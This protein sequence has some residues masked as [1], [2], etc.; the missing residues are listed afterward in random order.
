MTLASSG[1]ISFNDIISELCNFQSSRTSLNDTEVR[2]L[3]GVPSG[4]IN[5][6][7]FYGK[8]YD[9]NFF[10]SQTEFT[11]N[12]AGGID[13]KVSNSNHIYVAYSRGNNTMNKKL[14][15]AKLG[16]SS[17]LVPKWER[18]YGG[19]NSDFVPHSMKIDSSE[20][21]YFG[22]WTREYSDGKY[23]STIVKFDSSG[24]FLWDKRCSLSM[25]YD[26]ISSGYQACNG[27]MLDESGNVYLGSAYRTSFSN[28]VFPSSGGTVVTK[29]DSDG[30]IIWNKGYGFGSSRIL[31]SIKLTGTNIRMIDTNSNNTLT[32]STVDGSI[33]NQHTIFS[34]VLN[35]SAI[36]YDGTD[37]YLAGRFSENN[38][39]TFCLLKT[40]IAGTKIWA[41]KISVPF[42]A[43][44]QTYRLEYLG[45]FLYAVGYIVSR[46]SSLGNEGTAGF[47]FKYDIDGNLIWQRRIRYT[48]SGNPFNDQNL[49]C[50]FVGIDWKNNKLFIDGSNRPLFSNNRPLRVKIPDSGGTT[51]TYIGLDFSDPSYPNSE[52]VISYTP[53][54]FTTSVVDNPVSFSSPSYAN[55]TTSGLSLTNTILF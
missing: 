53:G 35:G 37:Y 42:S 6:N 14:H 46:D 34:S 18:I 41:K 52:Y 29:F 43:T 47:C 2:F 22:G 12:F 27:V 11:Y 16:Y 23:Y 10:Q 32:I 9:R 3:A 20:N 26:P 13:I 33:V 24:N 38:A 7:N 17:G 30:N 21:L 28:N 49:S 50:Q 39:S 25:D 31:A 51:G 4:D 1:N 36:A 8:T 48:P 40:N 54:T 5:T 15:I 45:G 19:N 44:T 55:G